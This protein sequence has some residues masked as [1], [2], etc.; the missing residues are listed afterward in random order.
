MP[1]GYKIDSALSFDK[2]VNEKSALIRLKSL[3]YKGQKTEI[4]FLNVFLF[5]YK[6]PSKQSPHKRQFSKMI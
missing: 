1:S 6:N 5:R 2:D 4:L 3:Y